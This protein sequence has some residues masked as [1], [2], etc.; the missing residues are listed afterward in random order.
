M[1][2]EEVAPDGGGE[3]REG[4]VEEGGHCWGVEEEGEEFFWET[5][6]C[7]NVSICAMEI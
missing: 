7:R 5:G 2:G 1:P 6:I 4:F 3:F